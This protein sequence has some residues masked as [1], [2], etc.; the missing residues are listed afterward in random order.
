[1]SDEELRK[2]NAHAESGK[3]FLFSFELL[4]MDA[5]A[6]KAKNNWLCVTMEHLPSAIERKKIQVVCGEFI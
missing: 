2:N 1:M 4:L 5:A 3:F 6:V